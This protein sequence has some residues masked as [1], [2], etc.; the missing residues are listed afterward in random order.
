M[1]CSKRIF[2]CLIFLVGMVILTAC[3]HEE[4]FGYQKNVTMGAEGGKMVVLG[5]KIA[6]HISVYEG[7]TQGELL[8]REDFEFEVN[9]STNNW[10]S[11]WTPARW[12]QD[13]EPEGFIDYTTGMKLAWVKVISICN[14]KKPHIVIRTTPNTTGKPRKIRIELGLGDEYQ[15]MTFVQGAK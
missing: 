14:Y 7:D 1:I 5:T 10:D 13:K 6:N 4:D 2:R 15:E 9:D 11:E 12:T 3:F 8:S